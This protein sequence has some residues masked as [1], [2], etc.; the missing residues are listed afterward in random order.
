MQPTTP[1]FASTGVRGIARGMNVK[2]K[3]KPTDPDTPAG[4]TE[5]GYDAWFAAEL[6]EGERQ[7]DAG[8]ATPLDKVRKEFGAE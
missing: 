5:A 3:R 6:T 4:W 7:L 2:P 8:Q 1:A